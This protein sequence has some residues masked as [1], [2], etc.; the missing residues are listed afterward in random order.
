MLG[1]AVAKVMKPRLFDCLTGSSGML[2]LR[3]TAFTSP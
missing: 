1:P 3:Q 2:A